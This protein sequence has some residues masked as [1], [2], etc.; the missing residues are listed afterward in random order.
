MYCTKTI[1]IGVRADN[2]ARD[3][4]NYLKLTTYRQSGGDLYHLKTRLTAALIAVVGGDDF[5]QLIE[6]R[7]YMSMDPIVIY[8]CTK[9]DVPAK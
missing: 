4:A 3:T 5:Q 7:L 1:L 6:E 8:M 9:C 2:S